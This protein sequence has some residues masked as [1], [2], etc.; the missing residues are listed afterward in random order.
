MAF[1]RKSDLLHSPLN[2]LS[3]AREVGSIHRFRL[4]VDDLLFGQLKS[5]NW[6][7]GSPPIDEI[8]QGG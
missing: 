7:V 3:V 1:M 5:Q 2:S 4:E 8:K 6:L